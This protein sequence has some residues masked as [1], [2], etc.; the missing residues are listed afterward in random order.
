MTNSGTQNLIVSGAS[1]TGLDA[2]QF[3]LTNGCTTV[4]PGGSCTIN[5]QFRPTTTGLKTV[6]VD[7]VHNA[8]GSPTSVAVS[9]TGAI[10]TT[11]ATVA[12]TTIGGGGGLRVGRTTSSN[13][14]VTNTGA[15]P[16]VITS[17]ITK[18]PFAVTSLGTCAVPVRPGRSCALV[19]AF[20]PTAAVTYTE[21]LT[22]VSNAS[23]NP[24]GTL[25]GRGR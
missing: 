1:L 12:N 24:T 25:T 3:T 5:V 6:S 21:T 19:V 14:R 8:A 4:V 23:N 7:I 13:V 18:A 15:N 17:A 22:L 16:L 11:T 20:S 9:G 2:A 10:A